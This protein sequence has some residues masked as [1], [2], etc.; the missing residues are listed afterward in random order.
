MSVIESMRPCHRCGDQT[1]PVYRP[2]IAR[3]FSLPLV[4]RAAFL[5]APAQFV[6]QMIEVRGSL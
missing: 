3:N 2:N 5:I 1:Q 6:D 4:S